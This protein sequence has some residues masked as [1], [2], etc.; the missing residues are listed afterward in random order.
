MLWSQADLVKMTWLGADLVRINRL[1]L[2]RSRVELVGVTRLGLLW[3]RAYMV[4]AD[5]VRVVFGVGHV[6]LVVLLS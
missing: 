3:S 2:L 5:P 4:R 1:G 6:L